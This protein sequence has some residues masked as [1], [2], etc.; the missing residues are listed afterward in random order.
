MHWNT[1]YPSFGEAAS[2]PDGLAVVGVF[3]KVRRNPSSFTSSWT[4]HLQTLTRFLSFRLVMQILTCRS[5]WT[6]LTASKPKYVTTTT[7]LCHKANRAELIFFFFAFGVAFRARRLRSP[8][9]ILPRCSP[10]VWTTGRTMALWPRPLCW[11]ALP[12]SFAKS[13]SASALTRWEQGSFFSSRKAG[14]VPALLNNSVLKRSIVQ[15]CGS[16]WKGR[17]IKKL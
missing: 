11:R 2:K 13:Q 14:F 15:I 4:Q 5:F 10:A 8:T 3:L 16:A 6:H 12:G 7:V 1:K 9:S 17:K